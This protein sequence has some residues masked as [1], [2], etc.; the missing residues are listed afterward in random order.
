METPVTFKNKKGMQLVGIIHTPK[1]VCA[2]NVVIICHGF[3]G[4]KTYKVFV[5][6]ARCLCDSGFLVLR[7]DF[8]GH[9][10]SEGTYTDYSIK[11][12]VDDLDCAV[13]FLKSQNINTKNIRLVGHSLG[14]L[15]SVL[16]AEENKNVASLVLLAPALNLKELMFLWYS[17]R[18]IYTLKLNGL[19]YVKKYT[20]TKAF[21]DESKAFNLTED[22]FKLKIPVA[23]MHG[24]KDETIPFKYIKP[25]EK[26]ETKTKQV[27]FFENI[28]HD[29]EDLKSRK[30]IKERTVNWFKKWM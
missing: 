1:D 24:K 7:F 3:G 25:L 22:I 9:G 2:D 30:L 10:D 21:F 26:Y 13:K 14:A 23:V 5:D 6:T 20:I 4:H 8:T 16:Y 29:F 27:E 15:V 17:K 28:D 18:Q 12:E 11:N 19:I